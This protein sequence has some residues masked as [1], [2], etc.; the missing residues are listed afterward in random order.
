MCLGRD[1]FLPMAFL[2]MVTFY[3]QQFPQPRGSARETLPESHTRSG[4]SRTRRTSTAGIPVAS[5]LSVRPFFLAWLTLALLLL[6]LGRFTTAGDEVAIAGFVNA[7]EQ[8]A[9]EG[10]FAVGGDAMVVAKQGTGLQRWLKAHSGQKIRVTLA[11][12]LE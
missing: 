3:R 12:D 1:N 4:C 2:P 8:D 10:Y 6:G 9:S 7:T 5:L 11:A